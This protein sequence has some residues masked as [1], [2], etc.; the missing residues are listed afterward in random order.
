MKVMH[1]SDWHL[2]AKLH[3]RDRSGDL[4]RFLEFLREAIATERPDA[5]VVSGD[6]FDVRQPSPSAQA[7]YYDFIAATAREGLCPSI[8]VIAGNHDSAQLLAAADRVLL[9]LGV[10]VVANA[11]ADAASE[12]VTLKDASGGVRLAIAAVP[13]MNDATLANFSGDDADAPLRQRIC[14]GFRAHYEAVLA[15]AK[16]QASGAPILATGHCMVAGSRVSDQRSERVRQVGGLDERDA[17]AFAGADY[18]ALGHL[19]IAQDVGGGERIR[20]C[21]SPLPMSFAEAGARKSISIVEFGE[22]AGDAIAI[23]ELPVP[24]FTPL[25]V[26]EGAQGEI[27]DG[28]ASLA[29]NATETTLVAIKVTKGEGEMAAFVNDARSAVS[30]SRIEILPIEDARE[31]ASGERRT[32][33]ETATLDALTPRDVAMLRLADEHLSPIE[34]ATYSAMID[35]VI[36]ETIQ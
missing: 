26:L 11:T 6:V 22:R 1:T 28:L 13:Y 15:E 10:H 2:G 19:H 3:E 9:R 35:D 18:V 16:R 20:Y 33:R 30:G 31:R 4:R 25:R 17:S 12:V 32:L 24:E 29:E 7:L 14:G 5:L 27:L 36:A 21:G 34:L 23:R 8:V